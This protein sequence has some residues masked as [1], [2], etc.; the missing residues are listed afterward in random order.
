MTLN[1]N[2][3][4]VG[5]FEEA[6]AQ[7]TGTAVVIDVFRAFTT[8]A[9]AMANGVEKILMTGSIDDALALRADG[10]GAFCMGER[11][12]LRPDGFDF[13]NSPAELSSHLLDG[14]IAI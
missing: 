5:S 10:A 4:R 7:A 8:A 6:A 3:I 13:G 11:N 12:G 1:S 14:Q 2:D 9:V